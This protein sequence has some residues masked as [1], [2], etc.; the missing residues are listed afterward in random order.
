MKNVKTNG[1][2]FGLVLIDQPIYIQGYLLTLNNYINKAFLKDIFI[3][4]V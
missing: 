2:M 1:T 4:T 3:E